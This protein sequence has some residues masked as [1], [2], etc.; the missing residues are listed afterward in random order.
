MTGILRHYN[1]SLIKLSVFIGGFAVGIPI[2]LII[3]N[4]ISSYFR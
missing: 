1:Y 2:G 4:A 3:G